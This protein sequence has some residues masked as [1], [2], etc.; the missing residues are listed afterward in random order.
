M[1]GAIETIET[2][3]KAGLKLAIISGSINIILDILLP[4]YE[5]IFDDIFLSRLYFDEK[6]N[7]NKIEATE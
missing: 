6:G 4:N 1:E 7:I 3:K 2:L 5:E